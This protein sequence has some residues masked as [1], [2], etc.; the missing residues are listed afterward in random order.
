MAGSADITFYLD[1]REF[2]GTTVT[3]AYETCPVRDQE[4]FVAMVAPATIAA[5]GPA[6]PVSVAL[7]GNP[8]VPVSHWTRWKLVGTGTPWDLTFRIMAAGNSVC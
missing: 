3:I 2:S 4:L 1:V 6:T 7:A 8:N 5:V